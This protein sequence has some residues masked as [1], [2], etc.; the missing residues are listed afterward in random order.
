MIGAESRI[1]VPQ[2]DETV[3]RQPG[4]DQQDEGDG[5]FR[6]HEQTAEPCSFA[7]LCGATATFI[8]RFIKIEVRRLR[9]WRETEDQA[10]DKC[11]QRSEDEHLRI[12]SDRIG[13]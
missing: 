1:K 12:D 7:A 4:A 13:L 10:G 3:D 8:Q 9:G 2:V 5:D 11:Y 6:N